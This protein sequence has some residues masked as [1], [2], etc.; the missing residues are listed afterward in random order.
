MPTRN[1]LIARLLSETTLNDYMGA[2][3]VRR[4]FPERRGEGVDKNSVNESERLSLVKPLYTNCSA[5]HSGLTIS[6]P[7]NPSKQ[8]K[9]S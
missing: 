1:E 6:L 5:N 7:S 9:E 3:V 8:E 4:N 2:Q